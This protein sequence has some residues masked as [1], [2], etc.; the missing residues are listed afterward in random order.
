[1]NEQNVTF[2]WNTLHIKADQNNS[3]GQE[4][5]VCYEVEVN[6]ALLNTEYNAH[7]KS[8]TPQRMSSYT[9]FTYDKYLTSGQSVRLRV[10]CLYY[11]QEYKVITE[12]GV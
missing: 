11:H 7:E 4:L 6:C 10:R 2:S 12:N 9:G 8:C 5:L 3:A 1:M